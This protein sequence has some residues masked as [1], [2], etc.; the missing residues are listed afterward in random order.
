[1]KRALG[2]AVAE[3]SVIRGGRREFGE[4]WGVNRER[5]H[6]ASDAGSWWT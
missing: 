6:G 2:R 5:L 1:M 4:G 3:G